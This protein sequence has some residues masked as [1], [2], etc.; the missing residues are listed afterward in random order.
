M[1]RWSLPAPPARRPATPTHPLPPMARRQT[2]A[3]KAATP[4]MAPH[5][6]SGRPRLTGRLPGSSH[7]R[8][9]CLL[10]GSSRPPQICLPRD[11]SHL[12]RMGRRRGSSQPRRIC[13]LRDI[14]RPLPLAR[15]RRWSRKAGWPSDRSPT[16]LTTTSRHP[17]QR[18][19]GRNPGRRLRSPQVYQSLP[20][21]MRVKARKRKTHSWQNLPPLHQH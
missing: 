2:G 1:Y 3:F 8:P 11:I 12:P 18:M 16:S 7:L 15:L 13:H 21:A 19:P 4:P 9:T 20:P 17:K 6:G 10:Q 5:R 14:F